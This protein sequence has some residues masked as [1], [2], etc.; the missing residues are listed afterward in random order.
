[1]RVRWLALLSCL[2]AAFA[3]GMTACG[4]DDDDDGGGGGEG[5]VKTGCAE[6]LDPAAA[7]RGLREVL[8]GAT[9]S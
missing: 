5:G 9:Q 7:T 4:D 1:M 3:V 8:D 2:L 6:A